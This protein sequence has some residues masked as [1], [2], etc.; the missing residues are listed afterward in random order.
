MSRPDWKDAP[1]HMK[2]LAQDL[3]GSWW[4]YADKPFIASEG[5]SPAGTWIG[6]NKLACNGCFNRKWKETLDRRPC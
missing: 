4:W 2:Y 6:S 1:D 5:W 3:D